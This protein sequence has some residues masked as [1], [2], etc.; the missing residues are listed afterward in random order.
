M[1]RPW[2]GLLELAVLAAVLVWL[3]IAVSAP[4]HRPPGAIDLKVQLRGAEDRVYLLRTPGGALRYEITMPDGSQRQLDPDAFAKLLLDEQS[5]R[6]F[7]EVLLNVSSPAG[8][9]WV[10]VGFL[11]QLLFTGRMIVQ[12]LVSE[13]QRRSVVPP[14]FWWMSLTGASMLLVYFIWRKEPIG[15]L[16]QTTGWFIY[17]RNLWLI[18]RAPAAVR[19]ADDP[20]PE[21]EL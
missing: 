1:K 8:L 13:Q 7:L 3:G 6:G 2:V 18:H 10:A 9:I 19:V 14:V 20:A 5:S 12:W 15:V 4:R 21:P 16:G 17:V 11:G